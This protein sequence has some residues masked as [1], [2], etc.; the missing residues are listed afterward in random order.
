MCLCF[1]FL[2]SRR[3]L[4]LGQT[5]RREQKKRGRTQDGR[6]PIARERAERE[7]WR[8]DGLYDPHK[9]LCNFS[10][11]IDYSGFLSCTESHKASAGEIDNETRKM[12][13]EFSILVS[14]INNHLGS[15][16]NHDDP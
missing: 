11:S 6:G 2:P 9:F 5:C 3:A 15:S 12:H 13:H 14:K 4:L 1:C 7:R 10:R 8:E 16:L